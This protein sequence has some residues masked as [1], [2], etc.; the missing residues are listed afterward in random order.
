[1]GII[2]GFLRNRLDSDIEKDNFEQFWLGRGD[3]TLTDEQFAMVVEAA[4]ATT[5]KDGYHIGTR[6]AAYFAYKF[7]FYNTQFDGLLGSAWIIFDKSG[8]AVGLYDR[9]D[10]NPKE[11]GE[12]GIGAE[13]KTRGVRVLDYYFG[14]SSMPF[15][16]RYGVDV[17]PLP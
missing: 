2:G 16:I 10:F 14:D 17:G 4:D 9:Y 13:L 7:D 15:D 6:N 1:L 5:I 8:N 3:V 12:R 11:W